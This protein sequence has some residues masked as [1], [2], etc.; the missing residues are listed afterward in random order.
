MA[1]I[2]A[3]QRMV[4][5]T[6]EATWQHILLAYMATYYIFNIPYPE[7]AD[8]ALLIIQSVVLRDKVHNDDKKNRFFIDAQAKYDSFMGNPKK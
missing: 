6:Q 8:I 1:V 3:D 2:G 4:M 5:A 7:G